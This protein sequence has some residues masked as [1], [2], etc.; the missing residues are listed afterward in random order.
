MIEKKTM[1]Y[2]DFEYPGENAKAVPVFVDSETGE[3][4]LCNPYDDDDEWHKPGK[5]DHFYPTVDEANLA[6]KKFRQELFNMM[7]Q[8]RDY[9]ETM[10]NWLG[11][12]DK[13]SPL[14]FTEEDYLPY[15]N[16]NKVANKLYYEQ[17][18]Y[19][20]N[21]INFYLSDIIRTGFINIK[22]DSFKVE[23][24][25]H[26]KWGKKRAKVILTDDRAIETSSEAE[27]SIIK[28]LFGTNNSN[29]TYRS[30]DAVPK[31]DE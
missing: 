20:V 27:F 17:E 4:L 14:H 11:C 29:F 13:D 6:I 18:Y 2:A 30:L 10:N 22:G 5:K 15:C 12:E 9:I 1:G 19:R 3:V 16:K 31:D 8:V 23:D 28:L 26:I 24:V 7:G 21:K 25:R